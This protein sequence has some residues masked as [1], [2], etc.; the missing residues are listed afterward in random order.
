MGDKESLGRVVA[1]FHGASPHFR[2]PLA[3][4]SFNRFSRLVESLARRLVYVLCTM[5]FD[6][7]NIIDLRSSKGS[8]LEPFAA[9]KHQPMVPDGTF[10]GLDHYLG[11]VHTEG[12]VRFWA[13]E[14]LQEKLMG[15]IRAC[16]DN[17]RLPPGQASKLYG[18]ANFFK[19]GVFGRVGCSGL[20]AIKDR[21]AEKETWL[22]P[23]IRGSQQTHAGGRGDLAR[24][25]ALLCRSDAALEAPMCG[26][27]GF[28]IVWVDTHAQGREGFVACLPPTCGARATTR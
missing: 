13:R 21:Q 27:G 16:R 9:E 24:G 19:L 15:Y 18:L 3:V 11:T 25:A 8:S 14:R 17:D 20:N 6:D 1:F 23:A 4:T 28:L 2:L 7:A 12:V 5:Y 22:T 10:L 26:T